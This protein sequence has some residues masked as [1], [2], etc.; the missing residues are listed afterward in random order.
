MFST[1]KERAG[2]RGSEGVGDTGPDLEAELPSASLAVEYSERVGRTDPRFLKPGRWVE[3]TETPEREGPLEN[4]VVGPPHRAPRC[5]MLGDPVP[6][7]GR[8]L[9][10]GP[11]DHRGPA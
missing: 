6:G 4:T 9:P 5:W 2:A 11:L 8:Q 1:E 7:D 3:A 10:P